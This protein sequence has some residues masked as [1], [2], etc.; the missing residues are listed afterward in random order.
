MP[1]L[2]AQDAAR[3]YPACRGVPDGGRKFGNLLDPQSEVRQVLA[4]KRV[5]VFREEAGTVPRFYYY[6]D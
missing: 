2:P 6:F 4:T 5:Y 3:G 1:F